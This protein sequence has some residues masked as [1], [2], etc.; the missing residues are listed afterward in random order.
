M[1]AYDTAENGS[2]HKAIGWLAG[3]IGGTRLAEEA[4]RAAED[5]PE[6]AAHLLRWADLNAASMTILDIHDRDRQRAA[7]L[8]TRI[9]ADETLDEEDDDVPF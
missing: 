5:S 8:D 9:A 2:L 3:S 7:D 4:H 6:I 1:S